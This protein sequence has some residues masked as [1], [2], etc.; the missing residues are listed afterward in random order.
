VE[1]SQ[2]LLLDKRRRPGA[3]V[4]FYGPHSFLSVTKRVC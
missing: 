1:E 4:R 3:I 2:R